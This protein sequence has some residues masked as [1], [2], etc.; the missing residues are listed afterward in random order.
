MEAT[1][2]IESSIDIEKH[3]FLANKECNAEELSGLQLYVQMVVF[4]KEMIYR[5]DVERKLV[6]FSNS[7]QQLSIKNNVYNFSLSQNENPN[8]F[9][10]FETNCL[11]KKNKAKTA[12]QDY[13]RVY[14]NNFLLCRQVL[15]GP[16]DY[17]YMESIGRLT[18]DN[19]N[20]SL[21]HDKFMIT[22][23]KSARVCIMDINHTLR[24]TQGPLVDKWTFSL[25]LLTFICIVISL[26]CLVLTFI[27]YCVFESLRTLPG[28]NNMCLIISLF[29]AQLLTLIRP[30]VT[31]MYILLLVSS[32]TVHYFWL[33][34]FFWLQVCSYHMFRVF[35]RKTHKIKNDKEICLALSRYA[36]YAFGIPAL[37]V[38]VHVIVNLIISNGDITGYENVSGIVNTKLAFVVTII[39]PMLLICITNL[40]FFSVTAFRIRNTP[41]AHKNQKHSVEVWVYVK[42]FTLTGLTLIFQV[43]DAFLSLSFLSYVVAILNGLQGLFLFLSYV[44][45]GRV[46]RLCCQKKAKNSPSMTSSNIYISTLS[47]TKSTKF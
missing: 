45:N 14:V 26:V 28:M 33:A 6:S 16:E 27:V 21:S 29:F 35:T 12:S 9:P 40:I 37:V 41:H 3:I 10:F 43:V 39:S 2:P 15:I 13:R 24:D 44:C 31:D 18:I 30:Y 7:L 47:T 25:S 22:K 23:N 36:A 42:L 1:G 5:L 17:S 11:F 20:V 4:I 19:W 38:A 34:V 46:L 8:M 32:I